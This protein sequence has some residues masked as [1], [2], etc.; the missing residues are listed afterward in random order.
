MSRQNRA[1]PQEEHQTNQG[2]E[3][4]HLPLTARTRESNFSRRRPA[5][6]ALTASMW[7]HHHQEPPHTSPP[8]RDS[9]GKQ[10][11]VGSPGCWQSQ[12]SCSGNRSVF[13]V[14]LSSPP[15]STR[16]SHRAAPL[17]RRCFY[18]KTAWELGHHQHSLPQASREWN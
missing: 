16:A 10:P 17:S 13:P 1:S 9:P 15:P 8:G 5:G 6:P 12:C 7:G 18:F 4:K 3:Q 11:L 2:L 14:Q